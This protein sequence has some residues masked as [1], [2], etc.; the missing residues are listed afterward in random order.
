MESPVTTR[1]SDRGP[2]IVAIAFC[3]FLVGIIF[4]LVFA[5]YTLVASDFRFYVNNALAYINDGAPLQPHF[6]YASLLILLS[7]FSSDPERL[8]IVSGF[9]AGAA[10]ALK[11]SLSAYILRSEYTTQ[12]ALLLAFI[13]L[14]CAPIMPADQLFIGYVS[15]L[16]LHNPT[17]ITALPFIVVLFYF[18]LKERYWL[19]ALFAVLTLVTKPNYVLAWAPV[20]F[21]YQASK[22]RLSVEF[23]KKTVKWALPVLGILVLQYIYISGSRG[24]II[25]EPFKV[26]AMWRND[27]PL[28]VLQSFAFPVLFV[29]IFFRQLK[30]ERDL[31]LA[32]CVLG[33]AM[34][35][36]TM[37]AE[38][39]AA[40]HANWTWGAIPAM[41]LVFLY[42]AL[43][44]KGIWQDAA[45]GRFKKPA[46][47]ILA[48][49][50]AFHFWSGF[51]ITFSMAWGL[52]ALDRI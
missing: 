2:D 47:A 48:I 27:I 24:L 35:H 14:F 18:S 44:L 5:S 31:W 45:V 17:T 9:V 46:F 28:V 42:S 23:I 11:F 22:Y 52:T 16:N 41:Y 7:D 12:W 21:I 25:I 38:A 19:V 1:K 49:L 3:G 39:G 40:H 33:V 4:F 20:Y 13:I 37:M 29:A 30:N 50:L 10:F 26:W 8:R 51:Y 36:Y 43:K 32:W 6:M 15:G 34:V